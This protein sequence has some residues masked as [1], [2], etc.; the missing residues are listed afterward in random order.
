M[1]VL[2][3]HCRCGTKNVLGVYSTM[4][5]FTCKSCDPVLYQTINNQEQ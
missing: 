4:R 2:I 5:G 1:F 3:A